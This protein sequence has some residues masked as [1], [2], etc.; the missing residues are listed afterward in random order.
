MIVS[1]APQIRYPDFYGIDMSNIEGFIAFQAAVALLEDLHMESLLRKVYE[2]CAKGNG[3]AL[4][5]L[6]EPFT[7]EQLNEKMAELLRPDE[8]KVPV[9]LVFQHI[10]ALHQACPEHTGDWFFT[11]HYPTAGGCKLAAESYVNWYKKCR[12]N[13]SL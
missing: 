3:L 13:L 10:D 6:Y 5:D 8:V 9:K 12:L 1:S 7:A 2:E 11:G 4:R